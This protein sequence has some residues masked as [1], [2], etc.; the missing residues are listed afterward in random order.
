MSCPLIPCWAT[1]RANLSAAQNNYVLIKSRSSGVSGFVHLQFSY[2]YVSC[3]ESLCCSLFLV[4]YDR[5][6]PEYFCV[7]W[8]LNNF[9]EIWVTSIGLCLIYSKKPCNYNYSD[10]IWVRDYYVLANKASQQ[11]CLCVR[12]A[13]WI[14][15]GR[16]WTRNWKLNSFYNVIPSPFFFVNFSIYH[17]VNKWGRRAFARLLA[18]QDRRTLALWPILGWNVS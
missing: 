7:Q 11:V 10:R 16:N 6:I 2:I 3:S 15:G 8:C 17:C 1:E 9:K 18:L 13:S 4:K 5:T 14:W 12:I